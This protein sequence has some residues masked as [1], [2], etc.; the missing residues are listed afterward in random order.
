MYGH[1]GKILKVNL[2]TGSIEEES[3]DEPMARLFLGG[4]LLFGCFS[5]PDRAI[6]EFRK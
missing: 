4:P 3:Y 6:W 5:W 1:H 2:G